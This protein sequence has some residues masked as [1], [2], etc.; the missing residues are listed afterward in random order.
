MVALAAMKQEVALSSIAEAV[1]AFWNWR[2]SVG[3]PEGFVKMLSTEDG[4]R[5]QIAMQDLYDR[6]GDIRIGWKVAATNPAVQQQLGISEPAFGSL[7]SSRTYQSGHDL[8]LSSL[9]QPHAECE[10]CFEI[11]ENI[12]NAV[13]IEDARKAV[14]NCFPAFEIIEKRVPITDF[15][16]AMADNAEHTAIVLGKGI[17]MSPDIDFS[18]VE[19]SLEVNGEAVGTAAGSAVLG[20]PLNSILWLKERLKRYEASLKPGSL[21]MTGSFLRQQPIKEGDRF[22][23]KFSG[24]GAVEIHGVK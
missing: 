5:V 1:D 12:I 14:T 11:N 20:N 7:R 3:V 19:C 13:T 21:V 17:P 15:G 9:V 18:K 24:V 2:R 10:I 4:F 6:E 8:S 23:A 22:L 16:G